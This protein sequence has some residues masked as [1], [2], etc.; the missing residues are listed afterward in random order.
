MINAR[1]APLESAMRRAL[2]LAARGPA[3]GHNPRVGCVILSPSGEVIAEGWHRGAGTAHAEVDALSRLA[4]GAGTGATAVV[5][6]EPCDHT[7]R[8]GPCSEALLA[9]RVARVAYAVADPGE[10]AH[11][12]AKRLAAAGVEVVPGLLAE[13]GERF[14]GDWLTAVRLSRP[15]VTL[16]WA[17]TLDGRTAAADGSSRWITGT[18]A[19]QRVH[20][21]RAASDAI[22]VGTGTVF[23]DDPALTARGDAGELLAHQA[24][25]VVIGERP[26]GADAALHRHPLGV[27]E[28]GTRDLDAVL[29]GLFRRGIRHLFVEGG[30]ILASAFV[31]A[32]LV[33]RYLV[34]LAPALL[35]G[36]RM[37]IGDI[38]VGT[39]S[40]ARRLRID[41]VELL[42]GDLLITASPIG[43]PLIATSPIGN[44]LIATSPIDNPTTTTPVSPI[45]DPTTP[46]ERDH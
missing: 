39:I 33:D 37:A 43:N 41:S 24:V 17:S 36:D 7:G 20:E 27:I 25:P 11:G 16:K 6:L 31:A 26:I 35:G 40:E 34:Y 21:Q 44:L 1:S 4:P 12:G 3:T 42:G 45:G 18:A 23:A 5:T 46:T 14:L 38:G 15:F 29:S 10:L 8:T 32:G 22:A 2:A 19:R 30:P 28:T 13:E 9:A